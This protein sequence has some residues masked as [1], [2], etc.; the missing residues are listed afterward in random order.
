M[1][2]IF[3]RSTGIRGDHLT[4]RNRCLC[5]KTRLNE[6]CDGGYGLSGTCYWGSDSESSSIGKFAP[7]TRSRMGLLYLLVLYLA[8]Q[9]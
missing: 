3:F 1:G 4:G 2:F 6:G 9:F 8:F 5:S 7:T